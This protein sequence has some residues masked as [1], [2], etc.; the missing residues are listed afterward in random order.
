MQQSNGLVL[1][2]QQRVLD[3]DGLPIVTAHKELEPKRPKAVHPNRNLRRNGECLFRWLQQ[4]ERVSGQT[5]M[6]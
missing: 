3:K 2:W 4:L 6:T 5:N 1:K